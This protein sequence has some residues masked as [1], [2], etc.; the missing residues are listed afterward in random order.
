V[1]DRLAAGGSAAASI[2]HRPAQ[3]GPMYA[4]QRL[5]LPQGNKAL[6]AVGSPVED[7]VIADADV[8]TPGP[9]ACTI[10]APSCPATTGIDASS[11]R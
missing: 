10:P 11:R 9:T 5:G 3:I 8:V 7:D 2:E 4:S 6:A 1:I